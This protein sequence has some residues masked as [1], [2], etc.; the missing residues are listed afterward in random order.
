MTLSSALIGRKL[1]AWHSNAWKS[2]F[3][4]SFSTRHAKDQGP[5][6]DGLIYKVISWRPSN[7]EADGELPDGYC[8]WQMAR[9]P[10]CSS[11]GHSSCSGLTHHLRKPYCWTFA[12]MWVDLYPRRGWLDLCQK[13][14]ILHLTCCLTGFRHY[15]HHINGSRRLCMYH[16][17]SLLVEIQLIKV[18]FVWH[19]IIK[20]TDLAMDFQL[21]YLHVNFALN[22][23]I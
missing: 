17:W 15:V 23:W 12:E 6:I 2:M 9:L 8:T 3:A 16:S 5:C 20:I 18:T 14:E 21:S 11:L 13:K 7:V 22:I 10:L 1:C 19:H 4:F